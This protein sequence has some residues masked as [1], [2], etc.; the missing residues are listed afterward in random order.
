MQKHH[1][2]VHEFP[3]HREKIHDLKVNNNHFKKLFDEYHNL[4]HQVHSI[5]SGATVTTDE[6]L[7]EL[8]YVFKFYRSVFTIINHL[9]HLIVITFMSPSKLVSIA[10]IHSRFINL[11]RRTGF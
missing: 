9:M 2:L 3:E 6:H 10:L 7:N 11:F 1:D 5:E 4:D 8:R